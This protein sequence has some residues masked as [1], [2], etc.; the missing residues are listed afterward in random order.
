M[1]RLS[2]TLLKHLPLGYW[3]I[4]GWCALQSLP[5]LVVS[6]RLDGEAALEAIF[7]FVLQIGLA[8]GMLL[9]LGWVRMLLIVYLAGCLFVGTVAVAILGLLYTYVG[10][11]H[12]ET[13]IAGMAAAYYLFMIWAW[14]YL[15]HPNFTDVFEWHW[16]QNLLD[17][18]AR[19]APLAQAA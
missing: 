1:S 10:L 4:V 8:A 16:A 13:L 15:F 5:L 17:A 11:A 3:L 6:T 18:K 7:G 12:V 19:P 9:R 14:F 2:L